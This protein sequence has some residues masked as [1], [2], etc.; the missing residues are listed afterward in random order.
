MSLLFKSVARKAPVVALSILLL[1]FATWLTPIASAQQ[2]NRIA[3]SA[4]NADACTSPPTNFDPQTASNTELQSYGLPLLGPGKDKSQWLNVL[5]HAKHRVCASSTKRASHY[6][7]PAPKNSATSVSTNWS[8]Y[9]QSGNYL[10]IQSY[11]TLH[12][13]NSSPSDS[14]ESSW[15]GLGGNC[16]NCNLLQAGTSDGPKDGITM[17][18]EEY[19]ANTMQA[20]GGL[21]C[22]SGDTIYGEVSYNYNDS[23]QKN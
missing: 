7:Q 22:N 11:W 17:W 9:I 1:L 23:N 5:S 3:A 2:V 19:P 20:V 15:V 16:A 10:E 4:P 6:P 18:W 14:D 12:F 8:G 13:Y 21:L